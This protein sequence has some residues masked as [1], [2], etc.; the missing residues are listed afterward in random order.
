MRNTIRGLAMAP[1]L[2]SLAL[3]PAIAQD[4]GTA[5]SLQTV[6][7]T[8]SGQAV[9][10]QEA[11]ASI[12]VI[13]REEIEKKPVTSIGELLSTIPGVTGGT[14]ATG[15]QS[16]IKLRG[17]PDKYTLILVDGKRQGSSAGVNYRDDLGQQDLDWITPEMI[18]RIEVVRGPMSSLYG[19]DAMGGV[20]NIITR[21]IGTRWAGSVTANYS[22]PS[23]SER[24]DR[25]QTGFNISGPVSDRIGLR[26]GGNYTQRDADE[27]TG[28]FAGGYQSTAGAK[29]QSLNALLNWQLTPDQILGFEAGQGTQRALASNAVNADGDPLVGAWGLSKLVH[30][31]LGLSHDGKWG[32]VRSKINLV[33]HRYEDKG[34]TIGNNA[35]ETTLD[36]RV[37]MPLRLLGF[38][39]ALTV[40]M[41][42]RREELENRDTI[43][44]APIDYS[45]Q[46]VEG[47]A[48]RNSTW[49]LF[50]EDS[51]FLRENLSLTLGL[52]MDRH[53]KYGTNW[54]PRAYVVYHPAESW[55]LRGGVSRGF[56][57]PGLKENSASAAT[58]SGGN[59][60][61][62]LAGLGWT[63]AS[64]NADGTRGCYMA[65]NP[66]L[67]PETSINHE[68]GLGYERAGWSA[69]A[70]YFHT[71]FRNKID[72]QPLGFFNGYW[73]TRMENAQRARTRGLEA[74]LNVPLAKGLDWKNNF[75]R[76][77]ESKN[78]TTGAALLAVPKLVATSA[79]SWQI[80][81]DWSADLSARYTGEEVVVTGTAT[82][83]AKAYTTVDL[84]TNYRLND[85]LTLR[86]GV[87]NL[88][89]KQTRETGANYDNGG[90]MYFVG[91]TA[92]F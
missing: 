85:T 18:E 92:R 57:A 27:S 79:V 3:S 53:R 32:G 36:G 5:Q 38:D 65:G 86:A 10:I 20:I 8:A 31:N 55:T 56:R 9:D 13:T 49:A 74:Y 46:P 1:C 50:G 68:L 48:L 71:N 26:I 77:F 29:N 91:A 37:D 24:G 76:M 89:D 47:S 59:G 75:T 28:G 21:K 78:L 63:S 6:V 42:W 17:L 80:R 87:I 39:Q 44:L 70:T 7:V 84:A 82:T 25:K 22:R 33:H 51:I 45:G 40:G 58:Q 41:Q 35:R 12:S 64:V 34:D 16:K 61:R 15:P 81:P 4:Q 67:Q 90:R 69:G 62:S 19:S 30:T 11:P 73:W 23:D 88:G 72:Y 60:C 2:L 14:A 43:G 52:R 83:F 54:S 66:N